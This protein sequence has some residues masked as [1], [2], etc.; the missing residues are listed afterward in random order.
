MFTGIAEETGKIKTIS[1]NSIEIECKK[2][3]ED[4]RIGDSIAVNGVCLTVVQNTGGSF[5]ADMS[6][7]TFH[8]TAFSY[9]KSGMRVN[10]ERA[11]PANGRFG[12]HFVSGHIDGT[13]KVVALNKNRESFDLEIE[14]SESEARYIIRKGSICVNGVSLTV[15]ETSGKKVKIAIIPHTYENTALSELKSND[16]VNIEVDIMAKYVEKFLSTSDN[17]SRINMDFLRRNGFC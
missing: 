10:L 8:V 5:K 9:L 16:Y 13:A 1:E 2:V 4:A 11:I 6:P 12:G 15:A 17:K 3:L 7:E 14:L